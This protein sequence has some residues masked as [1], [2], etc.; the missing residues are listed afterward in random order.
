[1]LRKEANKLLQQ[2]EQEDRY[3]DSKKLWLIVPSALLAVILVC[4]SVAGTFAEGNAIP[5]E[6][7][8]SIVDTSTDPSLITSP[9]IE[10]AKNVRDSVVGVNNY[11]MV[12][13]YSIG[14]RGYGWG[15]GNR[16]S[17]QSQEKLCGTGSGVVIT[18]YGH[19][20]TNYHV[21]EKA[22]RVTVTVEG[23]KEEHE[24]TVSGYD[25][26][27]DI[28]VLYVP[29]LKVAPV[30][31]GDSDALQVGEW[32]IV[33]GNPLGE[34]FART[35]TVG[36]VSALDR[37]ITDTAYDRYG[38]QI[39]VTNSMIQVDAAINSGNSGGG[40]FN[41]LGQLQG[42]PARK[43][44]TTRMSQTDVDN[45]GMCIP[46]N[47]AKPLI[48]EVLEA[49]D[50]GTDADDE[51][52]GAAESS[53]RDLSGKPRMGI[54]VSSL[55]NSSGTSLPNGAY[56]TSVDENSPAAKAGL[57][58]GDIIVAVNDTIISNHS[59]LISTVGQYG[60]GDTLKVTVFRMD[61]LT[62]IV[63]LN[64]GTVDLIKLQTMQD[65]DYF[66]VELT[67]EIVDKI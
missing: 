14:G 32:A 35:V 33:I 39:K 5:A 46:I 23:D 48:R 63:D 65:G 9:F 3:M 22:T 8:D 44:T 41:M 57:Q 61:G 56:I 43:Y 45:I 6:E 19:I 2:A 28:A 58:P 49:F 53:S 62:D 31:L 34:A 52:P 20:L 15:Y 40:M 66:E 13:T 30:P 60:M 51:D 37:S 42:I 10:V 54:I 55:S 38:R 1:M 47:V 18:A 36:V 64:R 12:T 24:A 7:I 4:V 50:A 67:L 59:K 11:Q 27:L 26:D 25:A 17:S 16:Y 21:I 29:G